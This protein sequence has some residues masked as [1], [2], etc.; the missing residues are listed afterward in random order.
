MCKWRVV[1]RVAALLA[2]TGPYP[3]A[4]EQILPQRLDCRAMQTAGFHDYPHNEE[5]Y[6]AVVF[7]ESRFQLRVN[8][9][10]MRHLADSPYDV[11]LTLNDTSGDKDERDI[12]EVVELQCSLLRGVGNARGLSCS[13]TPP[14]DLLLLN[15]DNLRF[16]RTSIGGWTF[17]GAD[18][19]NAGDSI[20]VEFGLCEAL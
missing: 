2:V 5:A 6:E 4:A 1:V 12:A 11:F 17:T 16:T 13:N 9:V 20:Y 19:S 7:Y 15:L 3:V 14:A 18:E 8:E 10:L